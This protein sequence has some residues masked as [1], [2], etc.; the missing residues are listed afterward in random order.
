[1]SYLQKYVLRKRE[2]AY[3]LKY[4]IWKETRMKLKKWQNIF[5]VITNEISI[6]PHAIQIKDGIIKH[7]NVNIKAIVN[8]KEIIVGI[9]SHV[10]VRIASI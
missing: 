5:L 6:V 9:L 1:M 2:K 3:M 4:L 8:G 7:V 10:F